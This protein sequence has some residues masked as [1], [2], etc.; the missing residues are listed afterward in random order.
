MKYQLLLNIAHPDIHN[1]KAIEVKYLCSYDKV[2]P[3]FVNALHNNRMK[4]LDLPGVPEGEKPPQ[5]S[6][7]LVSFNFAAITTTLASVCLNFH[8]KRMLI[9]YDDTY[10]HST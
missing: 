3:P 9:L 4:F 1:K 10:R 7:T 8:T 5:R 6:K 2:E